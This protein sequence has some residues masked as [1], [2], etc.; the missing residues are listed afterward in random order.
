[1]TTTTVIIISG[2]IILALLVIFYFILNSRTQLLKKEVSNIEAQK[3][4]LLTEFQQERGLLSEIKLEKEGLLQ[5]NARLESDLRNLRLKYEE[6]VQDTDK[7]QQ[8]FENLAN[9]I[10]DDKS[11]KFDETHKKGL[12]DLLDPL[13]DKIKSFEERVEK[14]NKESIE[15][16]SALKQQILG[17]KELNERMS[18]ET[19]NLT[20]AL[21]GSS[22][23]QGNWGE[24]ILESILEKSGLEKDREYFI[25]ATFTDDEGKKLRPDVIISLP[26]DK[27]LIIDSKVSLKAY[28]VFVNAEDEEAQQSAL[29]AHSLSVKQH[30]DGLAAKNYHDIY[31]IESPDFVLMFIP[32]DT[33][34][35]AALSFNQDLYS[36]AF[37]KNI[38]VVTPATLLATLKTVDTMW[39]NNKQQRYAFEIADEAGKM[40]DKFTSLVEDLVGLGKRI[41]MAKATYED[42][43]KK[44]HY[45]KGDL[46]TRAEKIKKLGAKANKDLNKKLVERSEETN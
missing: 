3:N 46:I 8:R 17:L 4:M 23:T 19:V 2:V 33:A 38:V 27:K 34:F 10:L 37:D 32:I 15:R 18:K 40:Y 39:K 28:E 45:G 12:R 11:K 25:Q 44:L 21:K 35:S 30:I 41:D 5:E 26:D 7:L 31:A 29:K 42:S 36:Y 14:T 22:K 9:K 1:M 6:Y 43:M 24:L 20:Q 13:K 16:N